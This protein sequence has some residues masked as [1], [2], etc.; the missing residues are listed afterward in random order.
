M[1]EICLETTFSGRVFNR[2]LVGPHRTPKH[3][4]LLYFMFSNGC[5]S[6]R[7]HHRRTPTVPSGVGM[8][9]GD[10]LA[11]PGPA[12][13]ARAALGA[14]RARCRAL[15]APVSRRGA[16][17]IAALATASIRLPRKP[18]FHGLRWEWTEFRAGA[19]SKKRTPLHV[20]AA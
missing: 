11:T 12:G 10:R 15:S 20:A 1:L 14:A 19:E 7:A 9:V 3:V 18:C 5:E 16:H 13:A 6:D 4:Q 8:A 17:R 2:L